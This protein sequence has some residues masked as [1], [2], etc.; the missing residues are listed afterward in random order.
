MRVLTKHLYT[1]M[2]AEYVESLALT[3]ALVPLE[4]LTIH[5]VLFSNRVRT[6]P[7]YVPVLAIEIKMTLFIFQRTFQHK[8]LI[9]NRLRINLSILLMGLK[10]LFGS[11]F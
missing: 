2:T 10:H 6:A 9:K 4:C 5:I 7:L 8:I 1:V 11:E 3:A